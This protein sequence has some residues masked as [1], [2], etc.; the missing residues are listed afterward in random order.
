MCTRKGYA[1]SVSQLPL[2]T[3]AQ[4][5]LLLMLKSGRK[6]SAPQPQAIYSEV[7]IFY[8]KRRGSWNGV[9]PVTRTAASK[10]IYARN[11]IR[12]ADRRSGED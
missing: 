11:R 7:S 12:Q 2:A 4:Y 8:A 5:F 10:K 1:A 9:C 3:A 6:R